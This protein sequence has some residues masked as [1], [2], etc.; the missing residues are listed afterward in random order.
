MLIGLVFVI[1]APIAGQI[2][3]FAL[4]RNREYLADATAIEFTRNPEGLATALEVIGGFSEPVRCANAATSN[5][6]I[7]DPLNA[8]NSKK[9]YTLFSTHPPI[10][11]RVEAIRNL[12]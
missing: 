11:K 1:L 4:S 12:K 7:S 3:K 9:A 5:M 2:M 6:Y 10:E 8:A